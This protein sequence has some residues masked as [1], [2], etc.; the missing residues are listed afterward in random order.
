MIFPFN[1]NL[2][3]TVSKYCYLGLTLKCSGSFKLAKTVFME[4][5]RKTYKI[6]KTIGLDNT[7]K[8]FKNYLTL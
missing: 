8:L 3:Q 6:K 1:G 2:L 4:K 7:C 5:A